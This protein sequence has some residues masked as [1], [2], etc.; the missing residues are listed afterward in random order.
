MGLWWSRDFCGQESSG[1]L[2]A[3]RAW[4]VRGR[5]PGPRGCCWSAPER[6]SSLTHPFGN[7]SLVLI[8][9]LAPG[10]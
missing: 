10:C 1:S 8:K 4:G 2:V 7:A 9:D 5:P 6:F 3:P